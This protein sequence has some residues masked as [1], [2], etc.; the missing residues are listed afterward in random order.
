[1]D[2]FKYSGSTINSEEEVKSRTQVGYSGYRKVSELGQKLK[3]KI[4][5]TRETGLTYSLATVALSRL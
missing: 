2:D 4:H 5:E 1:M 3:G